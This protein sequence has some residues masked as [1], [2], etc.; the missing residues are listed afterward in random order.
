MRGVVV[1]VV[2]V[3]DDVVD[4]DGQVGGAARVEVD[5]AAVGVTWRRRGEDGRG[6]V[7]GADSGFRLDRTF[8][9]NESSLQ[10]ATSSSC[11]DSLHQN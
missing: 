10:K 8:Y 5:A 1:V 6:T 4:E 3:V 11:H 7:A 9:K 2:V